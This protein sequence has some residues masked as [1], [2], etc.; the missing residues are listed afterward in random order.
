MNYSTLREE[1]QANLGR[2]DA[3]TTGYINSHINQVLTKYLPMKGLKAFLK[4]DSSLTTTADQRY[5]DLP[6]DYRAL[7]I[8][9]VKRS[10]ETDYHILNLMSHAD[11]WDQQTGEPERFEVTLQDSGQFRMYFTPTPDAAFNVDLLYYAAPTALSED[12]DEADMSYVLDDPII[13]LV[14]YRVARKLE[15]WDAA[16][17]WYKYSLDALG[18]IA[19]WQAKQ[20]GWMKFRPIDSPYRGGTSG[21]AY[22]PRRW[23]AEE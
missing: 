8:V 16:D 2:D 10:A 5:I 15:M 11:W 18:E 7:H 17:R 4:E 23:N 13:A 20:K 1:I 6:S 14:T 12:T 3:Q 21:G 19:S 22:G 9:Q